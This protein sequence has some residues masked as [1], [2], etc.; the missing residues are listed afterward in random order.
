MAMHRFTCSYPVKQRSFQPNIRQ[1]L[2]GLVPLLLRASRFWALKW[3]F[4]ALWTFSQFADFGI[5]KKHL[6]NQV[7]LF[8]YLA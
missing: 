7:L 2:S 5:R 4:D 6:E 1:I 8:L 3:Q